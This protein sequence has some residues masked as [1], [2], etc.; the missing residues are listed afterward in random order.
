MIMANE[1]SYIEHTNIKNKLQELNVTD[2][3]GSAF[4]SRFPRT[5][6]NNKNYGSNP[7]DG[8]SSNR[9]ADFNV[10]NI[11][12]YGCKQTGHYRNKCPN[13]NRNNS[14]SGQNVAFKVQ[15]LNGQISKSDWCIDSAASAH[16]TVLE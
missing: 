1:H 10:K 6:R 14:K 16:I 2:N 5:N 7:K 3:T 13:R 15:F 4:V 12:C 11:T 8:T 9:R